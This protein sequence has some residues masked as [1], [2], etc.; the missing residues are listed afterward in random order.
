M[1]I[2]PI[3]EGGKQRRGDAPAILPGPGDRTWCPTRGSRAP[4][5]SED[6]KCLSSA[7]HMLGAENTSRRQTRRAGPT[8]YIIT[9]HSLRGQPRVPEGSSAGGRSRWGGETLSRSSRTGR[10]LLRG[11]YRSYTHIKFLESLNVIFS[12]KGSLQI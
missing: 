1:I 6:V 12:G 5:N 10:N 2:A 11:A 3:L 7:W 8:G 9:R 4:N